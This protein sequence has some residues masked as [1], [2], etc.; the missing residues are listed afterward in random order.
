MEVDVFRRL[1]TGEGQRLLAE[2]T[3]AYDEREALALS[4]RLRR[5]YD[6]DLVAAA[7]SQIELRGR[8]ARKFGAD[9][10]R[11]YFTPDGLEQATH[12]VVARHRAKRVGRLEPATLLDLGCGIGSDIVA[13]AR[14]GAGVTGVDRD[15][16]TASVGQG[17]LDALGLA[18]RVYVAEAAEVDRQGADVVFADP[19]RRAGSRRLFD[20]NAYSPSWAFVEYLLAGTAV[21][22]TAPGIPHRLV[23]PGVEA[24]WVSLDRRLKEATLW[25]G[26]LAECRRRATVLTTDGQVTTVT[27]A[28]DPA[29]APVAAVGRYVYEPDDSVVRSHLVTVVLDRVDGWLLDPHL[30]YVSSDVLRATPLARAF[31]VVETLPFKEK[32]LRSALRARDVGPLTIKKRGVD[33]APDR[34]RRRLGLRGH[35]PATIILTRTTGSAVAL[36]VQPLA[37]D[38]EPAP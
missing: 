33:V 1:L 34:L 12:G 5:T 32:A 13:L 18:G 38:R 14:L 35:R 6:A 36:L 30:A 20:P 26:G 27:D 22:K 37:R 10:A 24:E 17:N 25:S 31:E 3:A 28:D 23:P 29:T 15:P 19:A 16:T 2:A 21:V 4:M 11:M 9:A 7:M 8:A